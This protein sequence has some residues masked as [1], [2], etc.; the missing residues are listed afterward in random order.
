M[1]KKN[2]WFAVLAAG[3]MMSMTACG[4][5]SEPADAGKDDK[6]SDVEYFADQMSK[7]MNENAEKKAAERE[8]ARSEGDGDQIVIRSVDDFIKFRDRVNGGEP[9]VDAVLEADL[10]LS[11][12]CG[13]GIGNWEPIV[14]FN[15]TFEG[16]GHVIR[17]LYYSSASEEDFGLFSSTDV[18]AVIQNLSMEDVN[19]VGAGHTGAIAGRSSGSIINCQSSGFLEGSGEA[20][21]GIVGRISGDG[22][23]NVLSDCTNYAEISAA[24]TVKSNVGGV[25]GRVD[26]VDITNCRNEG[27]VSGTA[28]SIGG[29]IGTLEG[30]SA[31]KP[32]ILTD[33]INVADIDGQIY[34]G[35]FGG[36]IERCIM[37]RC[38]NTGAVTGYISVG[39]LCG[40]FG[41]E[42]SKNHDF[43]S[44]ME[45]CA[46]EG[47]VSL[48]H[49]GKDEYLK[50]GKTVYD[51]QRIGGLAGMME[52][53][54]VMNSRNAGDLICSTGKNY[55]YCGAGHLACGKYQGNKNMLFNCI[56]TGTITPPEDSEHFENSRTATGRFDGAEYSALIFYLGEPALEEIAPTEESAF[57]DGTVLAA[58]NGFPEGVSEDLMEDL[59]ETGFSYELAQWKAGADGYPVMEW[60]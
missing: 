48:K 43:V 12:V 27:K 37:N 59:T 10:D 3:L 38:K 8:S 30:H 57:T 60:E 24:G 6:V 53:S 17:N 20:V 1:K 52:T 50:P 45:N 51:S 23:R 26:G 7:A 22:E 19:I 58:L 33:C 11:S 9:A 44:L 4:G 36:D 25:V 47:D 46:N 56:S 14:K 18:D 31:D 54:V 35:G 40:Y 16:N 39:G 2:I 13:E 32:A 28:S 5:K 41:G 15:G 29:V 34:V 21:G 49:M 55:L 42:D